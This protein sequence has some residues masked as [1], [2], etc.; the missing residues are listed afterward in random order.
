MHNW[1]TKFHIGQKVIITEGLYKG[2]K[3]KIVSAGPRYEIDRS[4][5]FESKEYVFAHYEYT[6]RISW[7][8]SISVLEE[9]LEAV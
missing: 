3:G 7:I 5:P 2:Q 6:V 1:K 9:S 8:D 4:K